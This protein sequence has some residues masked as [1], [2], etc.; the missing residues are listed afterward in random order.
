M[1]DDQ[2][3]EEDGGF[4]PEARALC[5][6][7]TCTGVIGDHGRC[8]VCGQA[9]DGAGPEQWAEPEAENGMGWV[10]GASDQAAMG[11]GEATTEAGD[12]AA[13]E[14][15]SDGNCI[16]VIGEAGRCKVCGQPP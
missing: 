7:G 11:G 9:G 15:C 12:L 10:R 6:D 1:N 4:D 3:V 14:L 13:R 16:G 2:I 8:K 5:P